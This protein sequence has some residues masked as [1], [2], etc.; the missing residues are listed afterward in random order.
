MPLPRSD[1]PVSV[2]PVIELTA[3]RL[4][5]ATETGTRFNLN[6]LASVNVTLPPVAKGL[7]FEFYG[8]VAPTSGAGYVIKVNGT[9]AKMFGKVSPTGAAIAE[10]A[11]KGITNTQ[12]TAVKG[13]C[14][15]VYSDGTDWFAQILAGTWARET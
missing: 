3:D 4:V 6:L 11:G 2:L 1:K 9:V 12:A 14:V 10:S 15:K 5:K 8:K 7:T 13:D